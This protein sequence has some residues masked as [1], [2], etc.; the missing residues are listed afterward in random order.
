[1]TTYRS[2]SFQTPWRKQ[3]LNQN[4]FLHVSLGKGISNLQSRTSAL[5]ESVERHAAQYQGDEPQLLGQASQLDARAVLPGALTPFSARQ[6]QQFLEPNPTLQTAR[7]AVAQ[8]NPDTPLHWTLGRSLA[9]GETVYVPLTYCYA[10]TPFED[11]RYVRWNSNGCAAGNTLAEA[12]L[13]GFL[14]LV[15]RDAVAIWWYN[16]LLR[17]AV[18]LQSLPAVSMQPLRQSLDTTWRYWVLDLTHDFEIPVMAAISQ[19]RETQAYRMGFGCHLDPELACF[20][21]LTEL[22]QL[23]AIEERSIAGFDFK[24]IPP[25]PY[26]EPDTRIPSTDLSAFNIVDHPDIRDDLRFCT[27]RAVHLGLEPIVVNHTRPDLP[28]YTAKV[29]MAGLCHICPQ[30]GAER[31]YA[32]PLALGWRSSRLQEDQ[33]NP[34]AL[35]V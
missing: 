19:H 26:L 22:C 2:L 30:L 9:Q 12:L 11:E 8:Y 18:D 5:C 10:N 7:Q 3:R 32:V 15:E 13:Q 28:I 29:M 14:E 35:F 23:I 20:R 1:M 27:E 31:L 6:Y 4:D 33:L 21:A 25:E 34:V 16:K 24:D 17:P